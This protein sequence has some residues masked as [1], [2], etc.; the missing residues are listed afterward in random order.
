MLAPILWYL[1]LSL[2]G[3]LT[4]PLAYRLLP[5]LADRGYA[6]CRVLGWLLWGY[7]FWLL[8]SLGV[9]NNDLGGLLFAL[10]LILA[11]STWAILMI[12]REE[13]AA[14][15]KA[16]SR[17][18][19]AVELV[20]LVS[21]V[22]MVAVRAANPEIT[23]TE[24]PM[25]LAFINAILSSP[26]LPPHDP[27]MSGYAISYYY[28]G[29]I[30]VA[31]L[32]RLAG[33]PGSIA[34]NLGLSSVF[35]L[36]AAA[37]YGLVYNLLHARSSR[38]GRAERPSLGLPVLGPIF[39]LL[40]GNLEG[41]LHVLHTRG[42]F[43]KAAPDGSLTSTF[44]KWLD[45]QDLSL[46][47]EGPY[48]WIPSK[49]WW[50]WRASR[51]LSDYNLKGEFK[52]IID[53]FPAFS[54]LLGDLHPHVL[55]MP[56]TFLAMTLALN[57]ALGG[58]AGMISWFQHR[59][60]HRTLAWLGLVLVVFGLAL[61]WSGLGALNLSFSLL[62]A[63][64]LFAGGI[65]LAGLRGA[66]G[67]HG[68]GILTRRDAGERLVGCVLHMDS[69]GLL[70]AI[71]VLGGM[72][73]LNTWDFP[74]YVALFA[75]AF[76]LWRC[77]S[78]GTAASE[79]AGEISEEQPLALP[80]IVREFLML[81]VLLVI[82][83][84]IAYLPFFW[85]FSS[86]AGGVIP[87]LVF[88]TRGMHLWVMFGILLLPI[89]AYIGYLWATS[90][91]RLNLRRGAILTV[92]LTLL[93]FA[94]STLIG[95]LATLLPGVGDLLLNLMGASS[96]VELVQASF[97]RRLA[98]PGAWITLLLLLSFTVALLWP[99]REI[100]PRS[101]RANTG[102]SAIRIGNADGFALLLV[103]LA[104]VL[105]LGLEFFYL[106][107]QFG[108][109]MNTV[110]KLYYQAW[111][112]WAVVA[113]FGSALLLRGL[114]GAAG[115]AYSVGLVVL[116]GLGLT[117]T[118]LGFWNKTEGFSPSQGW[119]LDG[120]AYMEQQSP[121]DIAAI[122]WLS[123]ASAGVV[124]EAVGGS[125]SIYARVATLSGQPNVLGWPGHESQWGREGA[126]LSTR[127]ADIQRLFCSRRWDEAQAI[128]E[129]YGI[130]YIFVGSLERSAYTPDTCG[131]GLYQ[132]KF[133]QSL[134]VVF[135][136]GNVTIYE[137]P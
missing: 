118:V 79:I 91:S 49:F 42:L 35:A 84:V 74:V 90:D 65:T 113:A 96:A 38:E 54:Y 28:F 10:L 85:S 22:G 108:S 12:D 105:V 100:Q 66:I 135:Q 120:A 131:T 116:L 75:A 94:F 125:Y 133:D 68:L 21:Y 70:L 114:R 92:S 32:A 48:S 112:M 55:A 106:R 24:K 36:S 14:W 29:Y 16:H 109:R 69:A 76:V 1:I 18:I 47:P 46:P 121:D 63:V 89:I 2:L 9:L 34:F 126:E 136:Q 51:V 23:G 82:A 45:I 134:Q 50:W 13:L 15:L 64:S 127:Q 110:F 130:R 40:V 128:I 26:T 62:G 122:R 86:Q 137:A 115:F 43:W 81:A 27:W 88:V 41:F 129:Q 61:L 107:D 98:S 58:S 20:F 5:A 119:S 53:E 4:F 31:V 95:V 77:S 6:I 111:L 97:A 25:E 124:A 60:G 56:F 7:I 117:Y 37:V 19:L 101:G 132:A 87:S 3:W 93:L 72:A 30:L 103:L 33:T 71:V 99:D 102:M 11:L 39:V 67:Q 17:L 44:W 83:G 78:N 104:G 52:E 59:V 73:F 123:D 80:T 8:A 57:L